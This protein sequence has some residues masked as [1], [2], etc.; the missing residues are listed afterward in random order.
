[1]ARIT[2]NVS[3]LDEVEHMADYLREVA[4]QLENGFTS[5]HVDAERHWDSDGIE[6]P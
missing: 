3:D 1:M 4:D 6:P 5:G 2:I